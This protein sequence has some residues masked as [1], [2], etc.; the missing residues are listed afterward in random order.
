MDPAAE[1]TILSADIRRY[2]NGAAA[3]SDEDGRGVVH[4]RGYKATAPRRQGFRA[5][6]ILIFDHADTGQR[7]SGSD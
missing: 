4:E 7:R 6:L 5:G 2:R 3:A 1:A